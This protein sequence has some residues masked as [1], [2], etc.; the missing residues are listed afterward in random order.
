MENIKDM[1]EEQLLEG[2]SFHSQQITNFNNELWR[3]KRESI[4]SASSS[5]VSIGAPSPK[6]MRVRRIQDEDSDTDLETDLETVKNK[7]PISVR[8]TVKFHDQNEDCKLC[9]LFHDD[10]TPIKNKL[11]PSRPLTFK[12]GT[13]F[14]CT[15][16]NKGVY[17][18]IC[19]NPNCK[20]AT[21]GHPNVIY[22][23]RSDDLKIRL[24]HDHL[25]HVETAQLQF[26]QDGKHGATGMDSHFVGACYGY[27]RFLI[28][29]RIDKRKQQEKKETRY[30]HRF[31]TL[32][33][34][35]GMNGAVSYSPHPA[36][37]V[38]TSD[39]F[40]FRRYSKGGKRQLVPEIDWQLIVA[41]AILHEDSKFNKLKNQ[42]T[43][44]QICDYIVEF[45]PHYAAKS[46]NIVDTFRNRLNDMLKPN[47]PTHSE[48]IYAKWFMK[49]QVGVN[50]QTPSIFALND[51]SSI[52]QLVE[53]GVA[54]LKKWE[55]IQAEKEESSSSSTT[56]RSTRK[57]YKEDSA[58]DVDSE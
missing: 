15:N 32:N 12:E 52:T 54:D 18:T 28:L 58:D 20:F 42:A 23:G 36:R 50:R 41:A 37:Q 25:R 7:G 35:I 11:Y 34:A 13:P 22:F 3:R 1:S 10:D 44:A 49:A 51:P 26:L 33:P 9:P 27:M 39:K 47:K 16:I 19:I 53:K 6:T 2:I 48:T 30:M 14:D 8:R 5:S 45:F 21:D 43:T 29:Q 40:E 4:E 56:S 24:A 17:A 46:S 38:V 57:S 31:G 55:A